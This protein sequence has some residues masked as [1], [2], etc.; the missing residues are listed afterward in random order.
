MQD[1]LEEQQ[2]S[3]ICRFALMHANY[4]SAMKQFLRRFE[5]HVKTV[6]NP[7][8]C[9][10]L[11]PI[12]PM[13]RR[14][15]DD[16]YVLSLWRTFLATLGDLDLRLSPSTKTIPSF[17][18]HSR[19]NEATILLRSFIVR[20]GSALCNLIN[21]SPLEADVPVCC[22]SNQPYVCE[23]TENGR[24][25]FQRKTTYLAGW[26]IYAQRKRIDKSANLANRDELLRMNQ[27]LGFDLMHTAGAYGLKFRFEPKFAFV[28][29]VTVLYKKIQSIVNK[30]LFTVYADRSLIIVMQFLRKDSELNSCLKRALLNCDVPSDLLNELIV[31]AYLAIFLISF[32]HHKMKHILV[33]IS[34][35]LTTFAMQALRD[36]LKVYEDSLNKTA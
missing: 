36:A 2:Q 6:L 21:E 25:F 4:E 20:F 26:A 7:S 34:L 13:I 22:H 9:N 1:F 5:N 19:F 31:D 18:G 10:D 32:V 29:F 27:H 17:M 12:L 30:R 23:I 8:Q 16:Q 15:A 28:E 3:D 24:D 35:T 33:D 14:L 11:A